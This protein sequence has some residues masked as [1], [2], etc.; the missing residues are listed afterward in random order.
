MSEYGVRRYQLGRSKWE[1]SLMQGFD[2]QGDRLCKQHAKT[3]SIWF[4]GLDSGETDCEWGR[5]SFQQHVGED[6]MITVRVFASNQ[7]AIQYQGEVVKVNDVL[8]NP[9]VPQETKERLFTLANGMERSGA[10]DILLTQQTGRYLW[11]WIE[12]AGEEA[13]ELWNIKVYIPGDY[14]FRTFPQIYQEDNDFFKRYLS[15]FSTMYQDFQEEIDNIPAMLDAD[16]APPELLKVFAGWMGLDF[17]ETLFTEKE[18]RA[19]LKIT[20]ELMAHKGTPW[21]VKRVMQMFTQEPAYLVE[22]NLLEQSAAEGKELY[23]DSPYDFTLLLTCEP[24][25]RLRRRLRFLLDQLCPIR[26]TYRIVFLKEHSGLDTFTYL[27][28]NSVV[29]S[30]G[31]G[32][33]D[34]K[35]ALT[36]MIYLE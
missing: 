35:K 8:H 24:D 31:S 9:D 19:L 13:A 18:Q 11:V 30:G 4:T 22:R 2:V 34:D 5:L 3:A 29:Q 28:I 10:H 15:I 32:S 6:T 20:P 1:K 27:D 23:G 26:S 14:F 21:A 17:G 12:A 33:L 25:Q 36:G 7:D 16:T